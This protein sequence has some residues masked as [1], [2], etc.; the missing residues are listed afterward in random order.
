MAKTV[1]AAS[2]DKQSASRRNCTAVFHPHEP[3]ARPKPIFE[4]QVDQILAEL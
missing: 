4:N 3:K 2:S 1:L